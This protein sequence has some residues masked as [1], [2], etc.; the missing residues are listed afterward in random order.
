MS[1]FSWLFNR[2]KALKSA[3]AA[4]HQPAQAQSGGAQRVP[5]PSAQI[6]RDK[7]FLRVESLEFSGSYQLSQSKKWAIAWRDSDPSAGRGGHRESGLGAYV[8]ADLGSGTVSCHGSMPRPNNGHV[9][10]TG[11]FCLEDWHFGSTLSGTFSVY[12]PS[13]F[14]IFAKELTANIL[15]SG[16]SRH[17]KYAFCATA[18]SPTDHGNKV[19]LFDLV[20]R[21]ETYCVS[22]EAGWPDSYEVDEGTGEL[23]AVFADMGSFQYD[24]DGRFIDADRLGNAKLNS[25]RYDLIILAAESLLG[26]VGLTDERA[27]EVLAAV[28]RA[29]SHGAD[30]N[31]AWKPIALKVQGLAHEQLGQYPEAAQVYEEALALNPKI[32]VKR[33]LT[34]ASKRIKAE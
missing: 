13:G 26:E 23:M 30:E 9:C 5:R 20:N 1:I 4:K 15:T 17:G 24:I 12:D 7:L 18:N 21:V 27:R 11:M 2:P 34:S 3:T 25:S 29:R 10:D 16:I 32:G 14:V 19:F 22:P 33:R 28:Q 8:L 6:R 31:P